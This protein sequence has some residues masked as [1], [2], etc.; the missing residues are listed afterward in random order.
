MESVAA[1]SAANAANG[2]GASSGTKRSGSEVMAVPMPSGMEWSGINVVWV[3]YTELVA[4]G[5]DEDPWAWLGSGVWS[6][7]EKD[8]AMTFA[9]SACWEAMLPSE[10]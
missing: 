6:V 7:D 3:M 4:R 2:A 8:S 1:T 10:L 5:G 9:S